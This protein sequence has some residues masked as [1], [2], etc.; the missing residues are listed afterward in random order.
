M[1]QN[2]STDTQESPVARVFDEA[3]ELAIQECSPY[4]ERA[5]FVDADSSCLGAEI[6]RSFDE[7]RAVVLVYMDGGTRTLQPEPRVDHAAGG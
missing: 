4:P 3:I 1:A 2:V 5:L 6:K 7:G